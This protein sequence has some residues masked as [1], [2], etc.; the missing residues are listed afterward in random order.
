MQE[1]VKWGYNKIKESINQ[2]GNQDFKRHNL[3]YIV[4]Y[5]VNHGVT[6]DILII[7]PNYDQYLKGSLQ[8][9]ALKEHGLTHENLES[10]WST[11]VI[12]TLKTHALFI[13]CPKNT[14]EDILKILFNYQHDPTKLEVI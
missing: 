6:C 5:D 11:L 9:F 12:N 7:T 4:R 3:T 2:K 13:Q 10:I 14:W 1:R 8:I